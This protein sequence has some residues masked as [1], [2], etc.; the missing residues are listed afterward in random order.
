[1]KAENRS[2]NYF[3]RWPY[4]LLALAVFAFVLNALLHLL[5][6]PKKP[7][8][9]I[10]G[11]VV[12]MAGINIFGRSLY[13]K[14]R[15]RLSAGSGKTAWSPDEKAVRI[16]RKGTSKKAKLAVAGAAV[17]S[18]SAALFFKHPAVTMLATFV[19]VFVSIVVTMMHL[20]TRGG[21]LYLSVSG[22]RGNAPTGEE[23]RI[24]W[25][26]AVSIQGS[27]ASPSWASVKIKSV[28]SGEIVIPAAL[29]KEP[30]FR[31]SVARLAPV[32]HPLTTL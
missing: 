20:S 16:N 6:L 27:Q 2:S 25:T 28:Q 29:L 14:Y 15:K 22:I 18:L 1:M 21:A 24:P 7:L 12:S 17:G 13:A 32:G 19:I 30:L 11:I 23:I 4:L 31:E 5:I 26:D 8:S 10:A 9:A 3:S